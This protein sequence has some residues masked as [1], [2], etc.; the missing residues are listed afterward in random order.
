MIQENWVAIGSPQGDSVSTYFQRPGGYWERVEDVVPYNGEPSLFGST[1][2]FCY[3][4]SRHTTPYMIVGAPEA[5]GGGNAHVYEYLQY[6]NGWKLMD[7]PLFAPGE[8]AER[9]D[10]KFGSSVVIIE[11][12]KVVIGAPQYGTDNRGSVFTF[13]YKLLG[14]DGAQETYGWVPV[15][16]ATVSGSS[17]NAQFGADL[18]ITADGNTLVVGE[19]NQN[20]FTIFD[21]VETDKVWKE[22]FTFTSAREHIDFGSSVVFL[23]SSFVAVGAPSANSNAGLVSLFEKDTRTDT[24][25]FRQSF[26]GEASDRLGAKGRVSGSH[27]PWGTQLAVATQKGYIQRHDLVVLGTM[28]YVIVKRYT[29]NITSAT[30]IDVEA[31]EDGFVVVAGYGQSD[32]VFM[33]GPPYET[34]DSETPERTKD[35]NSKQIVGEMVGSNTLS[36]GRRAYGSAVGVTGDILVVG[37]PLQNK[38]TGSAEILHRSSKWT[39]IDSIVKPGTQ[40]FGSA[41]SLRLRNGKFNL[42]VGSKSSAH[43]STS[44]ANYGSAHYYEFN[45]D[46]SW[47]QVGQSLYPGFHVDEAGGEF[48]AAVA[49]SS[50]GPVRRIAI[51][52]PSS[53]TGSFNYYNGR[54]FTFQ[55]NG[56]SWESMASPSVGSPKSFLGSAVDMM[57]DGSRLLVGAPGA[58]KAFYSTWNEASSSWDEVFA[59]K[60]KTGEAFGSS[61][62][63]ASDD[64]TLIAVG[65]PAYDGGRGVIR[66]YAQQSEGNSFLQVGDDII[67]NIGE[68]VGLTLC[69]GKGRIAVGTEFGFFR[70]YSVD[71]GKWQEI[72]HGGVEG[73]PVV[74]IAMSEDGGTIAT[75]LANEQVWVYNIS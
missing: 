53:S 20:K 46:K 50:G 49:M 63:V 44:L 18:D 25:S 59:A 74:S 58:D 28:S 68:G 69:G 31:D 8:A 14:S 40:E 16:S 27:G 62:A 37:Q 12:R 3:N 10:A 67:G 15:A 45:E 71:A 32:L 47:S 13:Q 2:D 70:V 75:G 11:N 64:G 7:A 42:L 35:P 52:A 1:I 39:P 66:M 22:S 17:A 51:G 23:S 4:M 61:V 34:D 55:Y 21:W 38:G 26:Q 57:A 65:G 19:P 48:G 9:D 41:I 5:A 56:T 60:G 36:D 30:S 43:G 54:I 24:W 29:V 33:Y 6:A 72:A 73:S